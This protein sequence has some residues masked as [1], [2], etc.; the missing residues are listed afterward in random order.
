MNFPKRYVTVPAL[1]SND[2]KTIIPLT[3]PNIIYHKGVEGMHYY[4]HNNETFRE[5]K[6][7]V[8]DTKERKLLFGVEIDIYPEIANSPFKQGAKVL[9]EKSHRV[10]VEKTIKKVIY[11]DFDLSIRKGKKLEDYFRSLIKDTI[12][13]DETLYAFKHW[14]LS[15][16]LNDG[17]I[18]NYSHQ[19]WE[20]PKK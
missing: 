12:I 1:I 6:D 4:T 15:Y 20:M 19:L 17:T 16:L 2:K 10:L 13:E 11:N 14:K 9:Y 5:I 7:V 8:Y 18:V 3:D